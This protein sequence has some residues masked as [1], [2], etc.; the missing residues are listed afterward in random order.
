MYYGEAVLGAIRITI[1]FARKVKSRRLI[2]LT[3]STLCRWELRAFVSVVDNPQSILNKQKS[4][5]EP[6]RKLKLVDIIILL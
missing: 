2:M 3:G 4:E 6:I 1:L 5:F